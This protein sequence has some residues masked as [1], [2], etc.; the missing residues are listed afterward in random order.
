[1]KRFTLCLLG[2]LLMAGTHPTYPRIGCLAKSYNLQQPFDTKSYHPV[3]C[4]CDCASQAAHGKYSPA[5]N[6]CLECYHCHDPRP[7]IFM[8]KIMAQGSPKGPL[9]IEDAPTALQ[10]LIKRYRL[11]KRGSF[12][13]N[14]NYN[15]ILR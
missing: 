10:C 2:L 5:R 6:Q 9:T 14:R 12:L 13:T 3:A 15:A 11:K 1:M 7:L 8:T 4:N